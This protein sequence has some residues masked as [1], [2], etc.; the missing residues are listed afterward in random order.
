MGFFARD[1]LMTQKFR[2][3]RQ[4]LDVHVLNGYNAQRPFGMLTD[5]YFHVCVMSLL[6]MMSTSHLVVRLGP[7]HEKPSA[8]V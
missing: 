8:M 2:D 1:F 6:G 4:I 3:T 5:T 7:A